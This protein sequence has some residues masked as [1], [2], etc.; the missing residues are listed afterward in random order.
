MRFIR[1]NNGL[2]S[3]TTDF[4]NSEWVSEWVNINPDTNP[5][6]N[7]DTQL[8]VVKRLQYAGDRDFSLS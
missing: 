6:T 1:I 4:E 2:K 3:D 5:D 8:D 7:T